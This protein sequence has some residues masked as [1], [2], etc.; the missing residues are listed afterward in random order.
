MLKQTKGN[1]VES[2]EKM[3]TKNT[4]TNIPPSC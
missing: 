3:R 4:R 2:R 1:N